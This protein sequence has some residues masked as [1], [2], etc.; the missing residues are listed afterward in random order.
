MPG[1]LLYPAGWKVFRQSSDYAEWRM[2]LEELVVTTQ[3]YLDD[4]WVADSAEVHYRW[5]RLAEAVGLCAITEADRKEM[6]EEEIIE[7]A[8]YTIQFTLESMGW[9]EEGCSFYA[10]A[11]TPVGEEIA[12]LAELIDIR[13][14]TGWIIDED[15]LHVWEADR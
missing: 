9:E 1:A 6:S 3:T 14:P 12:T 4:L 15:L 11:V 2:Y 10:P 5:Q 8:L 13:D 7:T